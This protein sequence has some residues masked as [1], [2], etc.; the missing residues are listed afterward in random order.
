MTT[1]D[2][3]SIILRIENLAYKIANPIVKALLRSPLHNIASGSLTLLHF[4]GR[5]S[6]RRFVTP[7]SYVRKQDT[8]WLLSAHSTRWWMNLR[9]S[10]AAVALEIARKTYT[11][12]AR[13]WETDSTELRDRVRR[14]LSALPR[15]AKVYGIKLD[16]NKIPDEGSLIEAAPQLVFVE[17]QLDSQTG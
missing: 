10:D 16:D 13:L 11:G 7:L 6:G 3:V 1:G 14:Y 12:K 8:V 5:K 15:D 17:I 4:T 9:G 2:S